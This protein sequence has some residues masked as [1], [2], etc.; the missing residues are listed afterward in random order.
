MPVHRTLGES[1]TSTVILHSPLLYNA[2][3]HMSS[4]PFPQHPGRQSPRL[5]PRQALHHGIGAT[6]QGG[7]V[8]EDSGSEV[9]PPA[10]RTD[11]A[12]RCIAHV[13]PGGPSLRML[14][15]DTWGV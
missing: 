12:L 3:R 13:T 11:Q 5:L 7:E 14:A 1:S 10:Q 2:H 15:R 4:T 6:A 8:A 9:E